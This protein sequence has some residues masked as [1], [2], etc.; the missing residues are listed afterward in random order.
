MKIIVSEACIRDRQQCD[1]NRNI[2]CFQYTKNKHSGRCYCKILTTN[3]NDKR[4]HNDKK[5]V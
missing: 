3:A 4:V 5:K 2:K 1:G